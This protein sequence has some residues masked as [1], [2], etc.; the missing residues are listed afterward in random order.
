MDA[1]IYLI[2]GIPVVGLVMALIKIARE[3]GLPTKFAPALALLLGI[4]GGLAI[5]HQQGADYVQGAVIGLVI[6]A[7]AAGFYDAA[8]YTSS[9]T[10]SDKEAA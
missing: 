1:S 6:G 4:V 7:S 9:A 8:K 5:A 10:N 3:L 2:Y